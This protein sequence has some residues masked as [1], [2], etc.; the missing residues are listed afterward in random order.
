MKLGRGVLEGLGCIG[1][2]GSGYDK[3][4]LHIYMKLPKNEKVLK[5]VS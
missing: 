2:N 3:K 1:R 5:L 4:K